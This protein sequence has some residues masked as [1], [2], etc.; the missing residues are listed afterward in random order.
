LATAIAAGAILS[1]KL[2]M[3]E[4]TKII[5]DLIKASY[6]LSLGR[7]TP[8]QKLERTDIDRSFDRPDSVDQPCQPRVEP[9]LD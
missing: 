4:E 3:N 5:Q 9:S 7:S 2:T 1:K 8:I 6:I